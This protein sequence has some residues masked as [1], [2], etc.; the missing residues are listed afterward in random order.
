[1]QKIANQSV[2]FPSELNILR[3]GDLDHDVDPD[4]DGD[5]LRQLSVQTPLEAHLASPREAQV[6][7]A[8]PDPKFTMFSSMICK[9]SSASM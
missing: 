4:Y 5:A 2:D 6:D 7:G 1:M 8:E 3:E 9:S